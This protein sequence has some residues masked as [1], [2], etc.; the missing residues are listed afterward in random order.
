VSK[1]WSVAPSLRGSPMG[2]S[3]TPTSGLATIRA[4][5]NACTMWTSPGISSSTARAGAAVTIATR[6]ASPS[7][8]RTAVIRIW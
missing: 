5:A 8:L 3:N 2:R 4:S 6:H 1:I 7:P